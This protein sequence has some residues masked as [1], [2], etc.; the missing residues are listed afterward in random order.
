MN[1]LLKIGLLAFYALGL[2]SLI[3]PLPADAGPAVQRLCL[4]VLAVHVLETALV[5]KALRRHP[6]PLA[7]SVGLSLLLGALHWWPLVRP[8]A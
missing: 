8:K 1:R 4:I 6:G 7:Q 5:F 3:L 2:V